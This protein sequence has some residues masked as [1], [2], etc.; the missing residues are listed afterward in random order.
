MTLAR[1]TAKNYP[2]VLNIS[3]FRRI[4]AR[5]TISAN[6]NFRQ[7]HGGRKKIVGSAAYSGLQ[8][9]GLGAT[10]FQIDPSEAIL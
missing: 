5:P 2:K 4:A 3:N 9:A 10:D 7:N 1:M 6:I 8:C